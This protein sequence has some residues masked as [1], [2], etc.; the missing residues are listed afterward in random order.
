MT[1]IMEM[2]DNTYIFKIR[3]QNSYSVIRPPYIV[4]KQ[5]C[6]VIIQPLA[7]DITT[8]KLISLIVSVVH[9]YIPVFLC[10]LL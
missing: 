10:G 7:R 8:A 1:S 3:P 5:P 4:T 2:R 6:S 9:H